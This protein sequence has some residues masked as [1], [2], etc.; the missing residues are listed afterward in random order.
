MKI[1]HLIISETVQLQVVAIKF[2]VK[3]VQL[4]VYMIFASLMTLTV[5]QG[6]N[7]VSNMTIFFYLYY[8]SNISDSI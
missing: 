3:I 6:H 5:T 8:N 1:M 4:K 2:A 7:F